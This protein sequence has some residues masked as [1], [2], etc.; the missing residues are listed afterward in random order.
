MGVDKDWN[1]YYNPDLVKS[2]PVDA[3]ATV[4]VHEVWHLLRGHHKRAAAF[5]VSVLNQAAWNVAADAEINDGMLKAGMTFPPG[6]E[7]VTPK[8]L[9]Q[10]D[11]LLAEEYYHRL[12]R[13]NVTMCGIG[14]SSA[15]GIKRPWES[16][17]GKVDG[18]G[19]DKGQSSGQHGPRVIPAE[20]IRKQV[21]DEMGKFAGKLPGDW[22]RWSK[23]VTMPRQIP[24]QSVFRAVFGRVVTAG[25]KEDWTY[26]RPSRR[27]LL[28][29][30]F[31][32]PGL[33]GTL[34]DIVMIGD[35]S[36]S[37]GEDALGEAI[38]IM[39]SIL[40]Y[41]G[42][43]FPVTVIVGDTCVQS[44]SKVTSGKNIKL[45]GGGGTDMRELIA[46]ALTLKPKPQIVVVVTDG[47]TPWPE[48]APPGVQI[49]VVLVADGDS[50][51]WAT[52]VKVKPC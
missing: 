14:G 28:D 37:M 5:G 34:P 27:T 26:S 39:D 13:Q 25:R 35:T 3:I 43:T 16:G 2:W 8:L 45:H 31:I 30:S 44:V 23:A 46:H 10:P 50:P 41:L 49:V 29:P 9:G 19:E 47:Y 32:L 36:G 6:I 40:E 15:D 42:R 24:W 20:L 17:S 48:R 4:L 52:T 22:A 12:P 7:P 1:C 51:T 18:E 33:T 11:D 21:A 38:V